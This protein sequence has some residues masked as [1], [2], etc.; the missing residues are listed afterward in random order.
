M[1][2]RRATPSEPADERD[3]RRGPDADYWLE[4]RRPVACLVFLLPLLLIYEVGVLYFGGDRP[5]VIRNGAD[6]WMRAWLRQ[7]GLATDWLLP[8]LLLGGLVIWQTASRQSWRISWPTLQGM[9][10]ESVLFAFALMVVGQLTDAGF[11]HTHVAVASTG[12]DVSRAAL[13]V[14]FVG[15]GIYEEVMFRLCLLPSA[16]GMFRLLRL[17]PV[18]AAC[19]AVVL[20]SLLFSLAHYV[21]STADSFDLFTF[22]FRAIAGVFFAGLFVTRGFGIAVGCHAAYDV[23]VGIL[24]SGSG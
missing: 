9:F 18:W 14:T 16:I 15:A 5:D 1:K 21:G 7:S 24:L 10:A 22:T 19:L 13:A 12:G 11:Q 23:M 4:A 17:G 2:S 20:S 8:I 6:F 3:W